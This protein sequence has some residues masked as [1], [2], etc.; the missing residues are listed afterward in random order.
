MDFTHLRKPF[1]GFFYKT[2]VGLVVFPSVKG[3]YF[4]RAV[5]SLGSGAKRKDQYK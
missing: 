2:D 5:L 1:I 3:E 4:D